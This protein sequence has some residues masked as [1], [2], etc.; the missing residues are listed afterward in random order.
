M[1]PAKVR[2]EEKDQDTLECVLRLPLRAAE[3]AQ[4]MIQVLRVE[5]PVPGTSREVQLWADDSTRSTVYVKIEA[6]QERSLRAAV[7]ALLEQVKL[8][9]RTMDA[10]PVIARHNA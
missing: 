4:I 6:S 8:I 3:P 9:L 5:P 2:V 1:Q 7:G 10:F